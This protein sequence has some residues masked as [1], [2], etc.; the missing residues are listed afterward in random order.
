MVTGSSFVAASVD[1]STPKEE[2]HALEV[3]LMNLCSS[4]SSTSSS[5]PLTGVSLAPSVSLIN[6]YK[7]RATT[8]KGE[9]QQTPSR[10]LPSA[11]SFYLLNQWED[12]VLPY[13]SAQPITANKNKDEKALHPN[14]LSLPDIFTSQTPFG[15]EA[16]NASKNET[17]S[18]SSS[19]TASNTKKHA[20]IFS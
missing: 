2:L 9:Q 4:T 1:E 13:D 7:L 3:E 11:P 10:P 17:K 6:E 5:S 18:N 14:N 19:Q 15:V 20:I 8:T 16:I 12:S